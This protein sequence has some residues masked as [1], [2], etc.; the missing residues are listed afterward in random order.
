MLKK[1]RIAL[2]LTSDKCFV[3]GDENTKGEESKTTAEPEVSS[4]QLIFFV[5]CI[6]ELMLHLADC[7]IF[8]E[9]NSYAAF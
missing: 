5:Y 6:F 1:K 9:I 3:L 4:C 7:R 2:T 8:L